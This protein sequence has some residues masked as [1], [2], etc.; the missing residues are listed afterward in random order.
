M[1]TRK[2]RRIAIT[3]GCLISVSGVVNALLGARIGAR[4]YEIYPGGR[5]GHVG[6]IAGIAAVALGLAIAFLTT[7]LYGSENRRV[8]LVGAALTIILGQAG[9]FAGALFVGT[10]GLALCYIAGIWL[11]ILVVRSTGRDSPRP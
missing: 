9:A 1:N 2:P 10:A 6:V 3:G 4:F 5:I 11:I 7:G 8:V